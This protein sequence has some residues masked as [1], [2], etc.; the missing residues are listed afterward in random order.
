MNHQQSSKPPGTLLFWTLTDEVIERPEILERQ[1]DEIQQSGFGGV[2]AF[3]RCSR[4]NWHDPLARRALARIGRLCKRHH[5]QSWIGPDPRFVSRELIPLTGGLEVLLFGD[6]GR[7]E[8]FPNLGDV[9]DGRFSVRC[10][11]TPRHVHTLQEVAIEYT[12]RCIER[13]Y[14]VRMKEAGLPLEVRDV[15]VHAHLFHNARE[16]YVEA[17]GELPSRYKKGDWQ[18]LP[19]FLASTNHVDF[20]DKAQIRGYLGMLDDLYKEGVHADGVMWDEPGFTCTYGTLPYSSDIRRHYELS[21]G[22]NLGQDLWKLAFEAADGS[23]VQVRTAYYHAVQS[24]LDDANKRFTGHV[25]RLW[26]RRAVSGIHDTWHFESADMCDMNHGSLDLWQAAKSKTG[27]FVDLGGI[28]K[29]R[30]PESSW[31]ANLAAMSVICATLGKMSSG[32]YAYNNLWTVGDDGGEGWQATVMDHC[33][34]T[35]ALFGTRWLAHCYGP[36]GTIGEE[37][38]FLGSPPM[39]GYPNHSTW[40]F[41]PAWNRRLQEHFETVDQ[42]LPASNLLVV[43][44]IDA[45]Y[46]H[47]GPAADRAATLVFE[48]LLKL[49]DAHYHVDVLSPSSCVRA[50]WS[51][52]EYTIRNTRYQA[53]IA[54]FVT[55]RE[56]QPLRLAGKKEVFFLDPPGSQT[57]KSASG[58]TIESVMQWL[59]KT[60]ELRPVTAPSGAWTTL[61]PVRGGAIVTLSPSRHGFR[62][63][64]EVSLKGKD[65]DLGNEQRGLTRIYFP[66]S[67]DPQILRNSADFSI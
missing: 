61:T 41:Y 32:A 5:M 40:R 35:M 8:V 63:C 46:A 42:R 23:H 2:A 43:F 14:A 58:A 18:V 9:T 50:Q 57:A 52:G 60:P 17:F 51:K 36:V 65:V 10:S 3:V 11:I 20:S 30:D 56:S 15:T 54:P 33:V 7:A 38:S 31:N 62:Y 49:L 26:G 34:N 39:P 25:Q 45:L 64:G 16:Q 22:K 67:G 21:A 53:V 13:M 19:F 6:K 59:E 55:A 27:G 1:F 44:P 37:H 4:Y 48:L 47:A 12:P 29:L 24:L 28:D 66:D